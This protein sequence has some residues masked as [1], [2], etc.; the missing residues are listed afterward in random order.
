MSI[1]Y[2][3][4]QDVRDAKLFNCRSK[5]LKP[6]GCILKGE[7]VKGLHGF[8]VAECGVPDVSGVLTVP[9]VPNGRCQWSVWELECLYLPGSPKG[10]N[11]KGRN[12]IIAE[13]TKEKM[14]KIA[15]EKG[16]NIIVVNGR[17][18]V[19]LEIDRFAGQ[20]VE[21]RATLL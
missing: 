3:T 1:T 16:L 15:A 21:R 2:R 14:L 11:L 5:D 19:N 8:A 18:L 20:T 13:L 4:N 10:K 6:G 12:Y 9:F 7:I 17:K